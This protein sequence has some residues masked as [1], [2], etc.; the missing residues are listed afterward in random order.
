MLLAPMEGSTTP[1]AV[2][3]QPATAVAVVEAQF[4]LTPKEQLKLKIPRGN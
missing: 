3:E 4:K 1:V 2:V